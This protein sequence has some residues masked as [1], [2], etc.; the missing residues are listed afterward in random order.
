[1]FLIKSEFSFKYRRK[2]VIESLN[3]IKS[4]QVPL[5]Q[6]KQNSYGRFSCLGSRVTDIPLGTLQALELRQGTLSL[7]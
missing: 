3:R 4:C 5:S 1:M 7:A 6:E 2:I